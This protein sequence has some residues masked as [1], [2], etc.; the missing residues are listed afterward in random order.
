MAILRMM[1]DDD[2]SED[3]SLMRVARLLRTSG[4]PSC[5]HLTVKQDKR[6]LNFYDSTLARLKVS[7]TS[8]AQ[9]HL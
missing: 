8:D 2:S 6:G 9:T 7:I 1:N 4:V 3:I 5:F